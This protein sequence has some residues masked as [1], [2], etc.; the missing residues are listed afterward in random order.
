MLPSR[1]QL[2]HPRAA[3]AAME[4]SRRAAAAPPAHLGLRPR[5][6][7]PWA[8]GDGLGGSGAAA[9]RQEEQGRQGRRQRRHDC[10]RRGL[11]QAGWRGG[12]GRGRRARG[13]ALAARSPG[14]AACSARALKSPTLVAA[15]DTA[16]LARRPGLPPSSPRPSPCGRG[17]RRHADRACAARRHATAACRGSG[18]S[19]PRRW[20]AELSPPPCGARRTRLRRADTAPRRGLVADALVPAASAAWPTACLCHPRRR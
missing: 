2:L 14:A 8:E 4:A 11:V 10:S 1:P 13:R 20:W 16:R 9:D 7:H 12:G 17:R 6:S 15:L 18:C 5:P 19:L 3:S